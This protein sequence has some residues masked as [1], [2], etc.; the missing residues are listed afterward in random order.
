LEPL[1]EALEGKTKAEKDE[2]RKKLSTIL[3]DLKAARK[4]AV[5][6][7]LKAYKLF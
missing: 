5:A 3:E 2:Q 6:K 1:Y 4:L 7:T